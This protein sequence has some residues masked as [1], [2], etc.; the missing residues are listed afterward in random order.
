MAT[1]GIESNGRL[2]RTAVYYNGE[3]ISGLKELLLNLDED[4]TFDSVIQYEGSDKILY[5]KNIFSDSLTNI[6]IVEPS[7]T[8]DEA[9]NL[10]LFEIDSNG[11]IENTV[12]FLN[13]DELQG[14]VN[15]YLHIKSSHTPRGSGLMNFFGR[16]KDLPEEAEFKAEFT[17][18]ND[19]DT[20]S[21]EGI[22]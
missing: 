13:S 4:G 5:N 6:K 12:V 10:R 15:L 19:D 21:T 20:L 14:I 7:F 22:F 3:Q 2:E 8:E 18:R 9:M 16:H 17:F 1:I 11:D